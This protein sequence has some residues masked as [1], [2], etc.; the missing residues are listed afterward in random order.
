[1]KYEDVKRVW[2]TPLI[3]RIRIKGGTYCEMSRALRSDVLPRQINTYG[4]YRMH[5]VHPGLTSSVSG[6]SDGASEA[7][8]SVCFNTA[9]ETFV[10]L[11]YNRRACKGCRC[12]EYPKTEQLCLGQYVEWED[13]LMVVGKN[14]SREATKQQNAVF[15]AQH[16]TDVFSHGSPPL[17]CRPTW[18]ESFGACRSARHTKD[19]LYMAN[20]KDNIVFADGD[21]VI[22]ANPNGITVW[23]YSKKRDVPAPETSRFQRLRAILR[24]IH[25]SLLTLGGSRS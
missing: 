3:H 9:T 24:G 25:G 23:Y 11:E 18:C 6:G 2:S 8:Q 22:L 5:F 15:V 17:D 20:W 13:E 16:S 4:L 7:W 12:V 14:D 21:F 19:R 1:M 10:H